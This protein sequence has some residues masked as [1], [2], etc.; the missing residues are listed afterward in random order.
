MIRARFII[1]VLLAATF[2]ASARSSS[3]QNTQS[4]F[5][6]IRREHQWIKK[7]LHESSSMPLAVW[8]AKMSFRLQAVGAAP[9][10]TPPRDD[11]GDDSG[12]TAGV[13]RTDRRAERHDDTR[14]R[15]DRQ[16]QH[17]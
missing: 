15:S 7:H 16:R 14:R 4:I 12:R 1:F 8:Q 17:Q 6:E 3:S 5:D 9:Q 2:A 11:A 13:R 10:P